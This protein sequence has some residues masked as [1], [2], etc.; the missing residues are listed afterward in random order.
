[1]SEVFNP[2]YKW[3]GIPPHEQPPN[4]Y[5][6]LGIAQFENDSEVIEAAA[7]QRM[8]HLKTYQTSQHSALSQKLLNEVA[9]A[10]VCLLNPT[11]KAAYDELLRQT[12]S[13]PPPVAGPD[14][15][16]DYDQSTEN[17][18][19]E[20]LAEIAAEAHTTRRPLRMRGSR[21]SPFRRP[22]RAV[23]LVAVFL[24][25]AA[26][27]Y[28]TMDRGTVRVELSDP[29]ANVDLTIDGRSIATAALNE[30]L[31]LKTGQHELSVIADDFEPVKRLFTV[32]WGD[33]SV[34]RVDLQRRSTQQGQ[35]AAHK[36]PAASDGAA[37]HK[38]DREVAKWV[39]GV[40]GQLEVQLANGDRK[41]VTSMPE[42]SFQII[43]VSLH[44]KRNITDQDLA[45]LSGLKRLEAIEL[46]GTPATDKAIEILSTLSNSESIQWLNIGGTR[47]TGAALAHLAKLSHL[48]Q[49]DIAGTRMDDVELAQLPNLS[50]LESLSLQDTPITDGALQLVGNLSRLRELN[51]ARTGIT[52]QGLFQLHKTLPR[53]TFLA[54]APVLKEYARLLDASKQTASAKTPPKESAP[55]VTEPEGQEIPGKDDRLSQFLAMQKKLPEMFDKMKAADDT[56]KQVQEE[57]KPVAANCAQLEH[58][59]QGL[60]NRLA[61]LQQQSQSY[62]AAAMSGS[63]PARL[64]LASV[65]NDIRSVQGSLNRAQGNLAPLQTEKATLEAKGREAQRSFDRVLEQWDRV[66]KAWF[67]L[68]DP[69]CRCGPK[70][71]QR[72]ADQFNQWISKHPMF[73][74]LYLARGFAMSHLGEYGRAIEDFDKLSQL[75]PRPR[76]QSLAAAAR[77][78]TLYRRGD[79]KEAGVQFGQAARADPKQGIANLLRGQAYMEQKKYLL[80]KTEFDQA[81]RLCKNAEI[82]EVYEAMALLMAACPMESVR[83]GKKAVAHATEACRLTKSEVWIHLDT[84]GAAYAEA[85]DFTLAIQSA[86]KA[87]GLAPAENQPAIRQRKARYEKNEPYRLE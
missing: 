11:K 1:M 10:K 30:P 78:Y 6:L 87:L 63:G 51:L 49:L 26:A 29:T 27:I 44:G 37:R 14:I 72:L 9:T 28:L 74:Q 16:S 47:I 13:A 66:T 64:R 62:Q 21:S 32:G 65:Q 41:E 3:L 38:Q 36:R 55:P 20:M 48:R 12:P 50:S 8:A 80:A 60:Q 53:C 5:R 59:V 42:G 19:A 31:K 86:E 4:H 69:L 23:G 76:I 82:P 67:S 33:N 73:P 35:A 24:G 81:L 77:G 34:I 17:A 25:L 2:Y 58:E 83:N 70:G 84:L 57:W 39:F 56:F 15:R 7:D 61:G 45:R 75:D 79:S 18:G 85:G 52:A 40:R 22:L 46:D 68:C 71:D 43:R 54:D